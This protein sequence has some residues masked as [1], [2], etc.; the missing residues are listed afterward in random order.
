MLE[1]TIALQRRQA[2]LADEDQTEQGHHNPPPDRG[3]AAADGLPHRA[4]A[5]GATQAC[6]GAAFLH[7]KMMNFVLKMMGLVLKM[8]N[9]VTNL[10]RYVERST[11]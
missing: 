1:N 10:Q 5:D 8:M 4:V 3:G 11:D 9:F 2:D 7:L 6:L